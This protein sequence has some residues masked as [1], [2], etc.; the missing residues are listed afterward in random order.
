MATV[1]IPNNASTL[2]VA[3]ITDNV[4]YHAV[5][6]QNFNTTTGLYVDSQASASATDF[7]IP[8][9]SSATAPASLV[10]QSTG[11]DSTLVNKSW[12]AFQ[13]SGGAVNLQCGRW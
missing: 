13:A 11:G 10:V 7:Y 1:S 12:Y 6:F 9:A 2:A 5:W 8:P 3:E 4:K